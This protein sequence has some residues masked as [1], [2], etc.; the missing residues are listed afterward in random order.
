MNVFSKSVVD[1]FAI[2]IEPHLHPFKVAWVD[3]TFLP[4]KDQ[5][6]VTLK[7]GLYFEDIYYEVLR[8][9]VAHL[10]LGCLW[11]YYN[12]VKHYGCNNTYKLTHE[13]QTILLRPAKPVT[14]TRPVAKPSASNTPT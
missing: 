14:G 9:N 7:I 10:L 2:K 6:L 1:K 3:K 11:L 12:I 4:V 13:K 8:M 5:C